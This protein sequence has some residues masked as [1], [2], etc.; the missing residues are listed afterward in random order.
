MKKILLA[1]CM[2]A[3]LA[4]CKKFLDVNPESDISKDELFRNPEGFE[5]AL[6][7]VYS[8]ATQG[9]IYGNE[10]TFGF[11]DVL[12][13]NY[14]ISFTDNLGYRQT[15]LFNYKDAWFISRKDAAWKGL[16]HAI[17]SCNLILENI[18][19]RKAL[20]TST[21]YALI[22][23]EA[24]A[25]RAYMH[26]DLLRM[27]APSFA[28]GANEKGI[29]YVTLFTNKVTPQYTV[30]EVL[31]K[32]VDDLLA[33]K[34]LLRNTDPIRTADYLVAYPADANAGEEK[35][36]DL[37][38]QNRRHRMNYYAVCGTL[39]RAYLYGAKNNEAL[40]QA[41]EV[42]AAQKFPW[43]SAVDFITPD[44]TKKD[45]ILYKELL[46]A[47]YIPEMR[48]P[49]LNRF[50]SATA[51]LYI[52]ENAGR[53]LF[54]VAGVGAE[55][56]RFKEWVR[57]A[58]DVTGGRYEVQKYLRDNDAN[59]HPLVAPALRLSEMYYIAAEAAFDTN[60]Q[61]ALKYFNDVRFNRGIGTQLTNVA[62]KDAFQLELLKEAR[63]EFY[64]EGQIFY[65]YKR[66][67]RSISGQSG[68][69]YPASNS[70]FVF[71]LPNDEIEFGNR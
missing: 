14:S 36:Q 21:Q 66:L 1:V 11:L 63:K 24:L 2:L 29:P 12:A 64:G 6:N 60:P 38:V 10:L 50:G 57:L 59:R 56:L 34:E 62:S 35:A 4:S 18:E 37:F 20:L 43:T 26:L 25:L 52:E 22:K 42:I 65:M 69:T 54:E 53:A 67:N 39:A 44:A 15:S 47:W 49:L 68:V 51:S 45:R 46:F 3:S 32:V 16:Y 33:A 55:D 30:T 40:Q 70:I 61:L 13:Q 31:G 9:D 58:L 41:Q 19:E 28:N 23:G 17:S 7:G 48:Q 71:P 8:R 5:E 27:F